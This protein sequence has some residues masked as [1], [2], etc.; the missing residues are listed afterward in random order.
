MKFS[1][2][3]MRLIRYIVGYVFIT[4]G[5]LK[6]LSSDFI[7]T[8][9]QL[10]IPS[11]ET[12][13]LL[14]AIAEI[15]CGSLLLFNMYVKKASIPL[16]VIIIGAILLTKIPLLTDAGIL[17]FAFEARLDIVLLALLALIW[18]DHKY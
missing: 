7:T 6:L 5:L 12:V 9:A 11:P 3:T 14:V 8:F 18:R 1:I 17:Q 2:A 13:V 10:G 15:V 16:L 4:S